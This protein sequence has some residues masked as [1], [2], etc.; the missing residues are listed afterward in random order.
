M[1]LSLRALAGSR[2]H[3]ERLRRE[4]AWRR[5]GASAATVCVEDRRGNR[6]HV[7]T[8]DAAIGRELF[9]NGAYDAELVEAAM[10]E[11][12]R[13]GFRPAQVVDVGAN[14][15]TVT[16]DLLSRFPDARAAAFEPDEL[17]FEL[18]RRNV[19]ANGMDARA[20]L[21]Q[22]VVS[23]H[24]GSAVLEV[25][26]SNL[27]DHRVRV[28]GPQA[29]DWGEERRRTCTVPAVRLDTLVEQQRVRLDVPTLLWA[30]VQGH[31]AQLLAGAERFRDSPVVLEIWPYGLR[32]A[33]GYERLQRQLTDWPELL[34][35]RGEV[36]R[37]RHSDLPAFFEEVAHRHPEPFSDV[38]L[39]PAGLRGPELG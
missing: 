5:A 38:L 20:E 10:A 7:S 9:V 8:R 13:R 26:D 36:T 3:R 2:E 1:R 19:S 31:E 18:L 14:I 29:G 39:L 28:G 22:V 33:G 35:V 16:I 6:F 11:L 27:G 34:E 32:R 30:D 25:A 23:D 4:R 21:H 17:N 24:D 37:V 12:G 15:G